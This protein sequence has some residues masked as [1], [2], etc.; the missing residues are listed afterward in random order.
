[1]HSIYGNYWFN[2]HIIGGVVDSS[3]SQVQ[4]LKASKQ[5]RSTLPPAMPHSAGQST[6]FNLLLL[7]EE[8]LPHKHL[9][10]VWIGKCPSKV[11]GAH[12]WRIEVTWATDA[13]KHLV[14]YLCSCGAPLAALSQFILRHSFVSV[15]TIA[16]GGSTLTFTS[17][18]GLWTQEHPTSCYAP[19]SWSVHS[20]QPSH[21]NRSNRNMSQQGSRCPPPTHRSHLDYEC[22]KTSGSIFLHLG[23]SSCCCQLI[24]PTS[25][26]RGCKDDTCWLIHSNLYLY[27]CMDYGLHLLADP[28]K[29]SWLD[30]W[31]RLLTESLY[32]LASAP[33]LVMVCACW[34]ILSNLW[35]YPWERVATTSITKPI[36][37]S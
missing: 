14:P 11:A 35:V 3:I 2:I 5:A 24:C 9:S 23:S 6:H 22:P 7:T 37:N 21:T 16:A 27:G 17:M 10:V 4:V 36:L 12:L 33:W 13:P 32:N 30:Y 1:M 29:P 26:F 34:L 15:R 19:I 28:L 25:Q 18:A 8:I 20:L 31:P